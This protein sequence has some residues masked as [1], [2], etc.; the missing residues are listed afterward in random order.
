[1]FSQQEFVVDFRVSLVEGECQAATEKVTTRGTMVQ[2]RFAMVF[3][4][5]SCAEPVR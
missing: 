3:S 2:K 4:G 1:M 5:G